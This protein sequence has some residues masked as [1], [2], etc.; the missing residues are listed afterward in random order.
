VRDAHALPLPA[1]DAADEAVS[2]YRVLALPQSQLRDGRLRRC[3]LRTSRHRARE[4]QH[5]AEHQRLANREMRVE[6]VVLCD[7]PGSPEN[8]FAEFAGV[9]EDGSGEAVSMEPP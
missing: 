8:R 9:G 7:E 6:D 3:D 5:S 1:G 2:D 4:P